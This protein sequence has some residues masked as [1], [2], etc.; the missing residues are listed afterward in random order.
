M[1]QR[2]TRK[3]IK[4]DEFASA[5]GR[6]VEYAESHARTILYALGGALALLVIGLG[7]YFWLGSRSERA[8]EALAYAIRVQQAPIEA[9]AP[10]PQDRLA[11]SF[12]TEAARQARAKEL[13]Q[14]VHEEFG[15]TDAGDVAGLYLAQI[16]AQEGQPDRARELWTDFVEEHGDHALAGEA[17]L[18]LFALDRQ[19]GKGEELVTRLRGMLEE[20]EPPLPKD[21]VLYELGMTLEQLNRPQEAIQAYQQILDDYP[22]SA[23]RQDAQQ[24]VSALDPT[25]GGTPG[26]ALGADLSTVLPG[27][28]G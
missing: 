12:A 22:Q 16:A 15:G 10:R 17:R 9:A 25:R 8:N 24:K 11:P 20:S 7:L 19:Q 13:F 4:R 18:N 2:L 21:A 6:S 1:N 28:P 5:V 23:Y 27:F 26:G 14:E 3:E